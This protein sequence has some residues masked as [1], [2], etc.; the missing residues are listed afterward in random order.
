MQWIAS[1][2]SH[3]GYDTKYHLIHRNRTPDTYIVELVTVAL[4]VVVVG[5]FNCDI[6]CDDGRERVFLE[7][8]P[9]PSYPTK[10]IAAAPCEARAL[11]PT[12]APR[13]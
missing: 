10:K 3:I 12:Q 13:P 7:S 6:L 5:R 2:E 9:P 4:M 11:P 8:D 1:G